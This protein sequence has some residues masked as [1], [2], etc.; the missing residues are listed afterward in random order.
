M[1]N[2]PTIKEIYVN[3]FSK[4]LNTKVSPHLLPDGASPEIVNFDLSA[5]VGALTKRKG[6][7][8]SY[9][10]TG[11]GAVCGLFEFIDSS[12][13]LHPLAAH[14]DN[15]YELEDAT[16]WT[17]RFSNASMNGAQTYFAQM[18]NLCV[19]VNKNIT[20]QEWSGSGAMSNLS[21]TPPANV[22]FVLV[23]ANRMWMFNSSAGKSRAHYSSVDNCED[24]TST[25]DTGAGYLDV[26]ID[27]GDQITGAASFGGI[28][29]VFKKRSTHI[30]TGYK[31]SNF[32]LKVVSNSI[33]CVYARTIV[34]TDGYVI[35][36]SSDGVYMVNGALNPILASD[37]IQP[38]IDALSDTAKVAAAAGLLR[39]QYWLSYDSDADTQNDSTY[40]LD[41]VDGMWTRYSN[42]KASCYWTKRNATLFAGDPNARKVRQFDTGTQDESTDITATWKSK[43]FDDGSFVEDKQLMDFWLYADGSSGKTITLNTF[44]NDV[45]NADAPSI[46]LTPS[47]PSASAA[48]VMVGQNLPDS[49]QNRNF[50]FKLT[51]ANASYLSRIHAISCLFERLPRPY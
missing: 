31:P 35:F 24:W 14:D 45:S 6:Q 3:D 33:G 25:G 5:K 16:T 9:S 28:I 26:A 39:H 23:H 17:S 37:G 13:A 22:G 46:S 18:N 42:T 44:L 27:D 15:I 19:A 41:F 7:A 20:T 30:I 50:A 2:T 38:T 12:D 36:L 51:D 47:D 29:F 49:L 10:T 21:G 34:N 11:T 48:T 40:V 43:T 8:L 4:G 32:I 1:A